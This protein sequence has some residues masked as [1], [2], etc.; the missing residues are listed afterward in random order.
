M[1]KM[2]AEELCSKCGKKIRTGRTGSLTQWLF[3]EDTC[4]CDGK[5]PSLKMP[6][7]EP[8]LEESRMCEH[9]GKLRS[10]SR[11]GSLT[12]WVF[13]AE[14]CSCDYEKLKQSHSGELGEQAREAK[15]IET[16]SYSGDIPV[17]LQD[18]LENGPVNFHGLA[19][20]SFPF[21][22][23]RIID[24]KGRGFAGIVYEA[25]DLILRKRVAIKTLY[26][27]AWSAEELVRF[28]S[29]ARAS[30]RLSHR[31][32]LQILD[33]GSSEGG[34]PYMVME[35]V[36]GITLSELIKREGSIESKDAVPLFLQ[37]CEGVRHA[38]HSG[39][40]HRDIKSS[41]IM[42]ARDR[43]GNQIAKVID[44]GIAALA[45]H[46][47]TVS[48]AG[49]SKTESIAG[50]PHYM[51]PDQF[52]GHPY[53]IRSDIYSIGCVMYETLC[54]VVP[55]EAENVM[56]TMSLHASA[57]IPDLI[58]TYGES[59]SCPTEL[60][61]IVRKCL[62]KDPSGRFKNTDELH[63]HLLDVNEKLGLPPP[64]IN[65]DSD[66]VSFK[67]PY[68]KFKTPFIIA[69]VFALL[70]TVGFLSYKGISALPA[71]KAVPSTS[72][73]LLFDK[74]APDETP[75]QIMSKDPFADLAT[76]GLIV[77]W[78]EKQGRLTI[79]G[80]Q[81]PDKILRRALKRKYPVIELEI[82]N[83]V[84]SD[85]TFSM[86]SQL[87]DLK[88]LSLSDVSGAKPEDWHELGKC[89]DLHHLRLTDINATDDF[90]AMVGQLKFL[91]HLDIDSSTVSA[92][93]LSYLTKLPLEHLSL[94][95]SKLSSAHMKEIVKIKT[96]NQI[97]LGDTSLSDADLKSL[98]SLDVVFALGLN[99]LPIEDET[100]LA[101]VK[102]FPLKALY[103]FRCEK[104]T[105]K[106]IRRVS[107]MRPSCSILDDDS[108]IKNSFAPMQ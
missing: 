44:F 6:E 65:E 51:A 103:V 95:T 69:A 7:L 55:Y 19:E 102:K 12:Q 33:F 49:V 10:D 2:S 70:C 9:C 3:T 90:M 92:K 79:D 36:D 73:M 63:K 46:E 64:P 17:E 76:H 16:A 21:E 89:K 27:K 48:R 42:I 84:M 78:S 18:A 105:P 74:D 30:S 8:S 28:Q 13:G 15:E 34:Q 97:F 39:I 60:S 107:A 26:S 83:A 75:E 23:Y 88:M 52:R 40:L 87:P 82:D 53:E 29:E 11:Q 50:S 57:E 98:L 91:D 104:L 68:E 20:N 72:K 80:E 1:L 14:R 37:I 85:E 32:V 54:G 31:N 62:A 96:L 93:G 43:T 99:G 4:E 22:R 56:A 81:S 101:L 71:P 41:N 67:R 45:H 59:V 24:E 5:L 38:H 58:N 100:L 108:D 25:W 66:S 47:E 94:K 106:M 77:Q 86:I 61:A 35:F